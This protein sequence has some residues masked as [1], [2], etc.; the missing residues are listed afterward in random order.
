M[1]L[2][3]S[4][5]GHTVEG[6]YVKIV[7]GKELNIRLA[8][9]IAAPGNLLYPAYQ[10]ARKAV[11][12]I[13]EQTINFLDEL[14]ENETPCQV[15][16]L[17]ARYN[18]N[19]IAFEAQ[20][21]Y[22]KTQTMLSF[23]SLLDKTCKEPTDSSS[24]IKGM[25]FIVLPMIA[26]SAMEEDQKLLYVI[27]SRFYN[28]AQKLAECL[29]YDKD[30]FTLS[31]LLQNCLSG[32]NGLK[33]IK[34]SGCDNS[35]D[36]FETLQDVSDGMALRYHFWKLIHFLNQH[37][38]GKT[39][40]VIQLDDVDSQI[41]YGYQVMDDIRK[42]LVIP[43][44]IILISTDGDLLYRAILE[45]HLNQFQRLRE[46][47]PQQ[48]VSLLSK[49]SNKYVDKLIPPSHM[50]HLPRIEQY[51]GS[52]INEG[53]RL[54]YLTKDLDIASCS[55]TKLMEACVFNWEKD[56]EWDLE[57][58]LFRAIYEKTGLAFAKHSNYMHNIIPKS[59]RGL[60]QLL[61]LLKKMEEVPPFTDDSFK[62]EKAY[63]N[64]WEKRIASLEINLALFESYFINEW[65]DAKISRIDR[66]RNDREFLRNLIKAPKDDRIILTI[67]Y[68]T[69]KFGVQ[70]YQRRQNE[71]LEKMQSLETE[72][73]I[74]GN[75][76]NEEK[77]RK[78]IELEQSLEEVK[79]ELADIK[80]R[81]PGYSRISLNHYML[82][83][84]ISNRE[85]ED[86]LLFFSIHVIL[87]I[88]S[89]ILVLKQRKHA[90]ED[91]LNGQKKNGEEEEEKKISYSGFNHYLAFDFDPQITSLPPTCLT[92]GEDELN[93]FT[94]KHINK[95]FK[96]VM[97]FPKDCNTNKSIYDYKREEEKNVEHGADD[98]T[99]I[100]YQPTQKYYKSIRESLFAP[101]EKEGE[102]LLSVFNFP[103]VLL[104]LGKTYNPE[105]SAGDNASYT[106]KLLYLYQE[107]AVFILGNWDV[108]EKIYKY[109]LSTIPENLAGKDYEYYNKTVIRELTGSNL[110]GVLFRGVDAILSKYFSPLGDVLFS[111]LEVFSIENNL[112]NAFK[113]LFTSQKLVGEKNAFFTVTAFA[114]IFSAL[115]FKDF[116]P[117]NPEKEEFDE[118]RTGFIG[119]K[120]L[121]SESKLPTRNDS[122]Q[123]S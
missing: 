54:Y 61:Y 64:A 10:Q 92:P 82:Q 86:Y 31:S 116:D 117:K 112:E 57:N 108:Q 101:T 89:H 36:D 83:L 72:I 14:K 73:K 56:V 44:L 115:F 24:C 50:V 58:V 17:L 39:F 59:L 45:E 16:E 100:H 63:L 97:R 119:K 32:I 48:N 37:N 123:D 120:G 90:I 75:V 41:K 99:Q 7:Q 53:L 81:K 1:P 85:S 69:E 110:C 52:G 5:N 30:R 122:G 114:A 55:A 2:Y 80:N 12:E 9:E 22:G 102:Y 98:P 8:S 74:I 96:P 28:Y 121:S 94:E 6:K 66:E 109:L 47:A 76:R 46:V 95:C 111:K 4:N 118:E 42:Y 23:S 38:D 71:L 62:N 43:N 35:C 19:I 67:D 113:N 70:S 13:V 93:S 87:D 88:E 79:K 18:G 34:N 78:K 65:V 60:S 11:M 104:N 107:L 25:R 49:I 27:L 21:G 51:L 84:S 105:P 91:R 77:K 3:D 103:I 68:L 20:R 15:N 40:F 29:P 26:P 33:K 106:Q